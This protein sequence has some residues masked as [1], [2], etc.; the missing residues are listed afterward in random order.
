[1]DEFPRLFH[2]PE[3]SF[4][5]FGPR[6][7]GK[8]TLLEKKHG[9]NSIWID[10]L[11]PDI[12]RQYFSY[13]ERLHDV[14]QGNPDKKII[15]IDE[16]QKAP[17]LLSV[18]HQLIERKKS[19]QFILTGSS[20]RKLKATG[21]DLLGGRALK[22]TL[23]PFMAAELGTAFNLQ[24]ALQHGLLPLIW[25]AKEAASVLHAYINLYLKEEIQ[26]EGL[27]RNLEDFA[28]FLEVISF[29]HAEQ[30]N[31]TNIARE[32]EVKRK[33]VENYVNILEDLLL[34]FH[35]NVF[36]KRAQ[37]ELVSH[38]KFY[39]FDSGIFHAL[40]PRGILDSVD[41]INGAA[42]EGLIAQHLRAW[43]DYSKVKHSLYYWRTRAGLEVDFIIY[44][45][46]YFYAIEVKNSKRVHNTD[47]KSLK[48]FLDDYPQA[49]ALL[50]YQG[51]EMLKID[52]V[53]CVPSHKF[54]MQ[55]KPNNPLFIGE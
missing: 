22:C 5:L 2:E 1:M 33:T 54:L 25:E 47:I 29:S 38:P 50:L 17:Q 27:V 7:T 43:I 32:C 24:R 21:A 36:D 37:R 13:P 30:L 45:E 15:V 8:S 3:S 28:R 46:K 48:T 52:N 19:L 14:V 20:S 6:G 12:V 26:A 31:I 16:V 49:K 42:L 10:L 40:R 18:V 44:G 51:E 34:G 11:R 55:L 39:L 35:I 53:L 9:E 23:H 4:F 41:E